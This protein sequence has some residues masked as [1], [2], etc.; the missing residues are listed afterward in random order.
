MP[1]ALGLSPDLDLTFNLQIHQGFFQFLGKDDICQFVGL[2]IFNT[3]I[4][5]MFLCNISFYKPYTMYILHL[6]LTLLTLVCIALPTYIK[7]N[8]LLQ[9]D[10]IQITSDLHISPHKPVCDSCSDYSCYQYFKYISSKKINSINSRIHSYHQRKNLLR[11]FL[12]KCDN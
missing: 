1:R 6:A 4:K 11:Y 12:L 8:C 10:L 3:C 7:I 2:L 9:L 5:R